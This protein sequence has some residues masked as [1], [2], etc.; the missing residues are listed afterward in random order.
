MGNA[1]SVTQT[2]KPFFSPN[3]MQILRIKYNFEEGTACGATEMST[4]VR[5]IKNR[6]TRVKIKF[7]VAF[8]SFGIDTKKKKVRFLFAVIFTKANTRTWQKKAG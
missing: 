2:A 8:I 3:D 6:K 5:E 4:T 1:N 7:D